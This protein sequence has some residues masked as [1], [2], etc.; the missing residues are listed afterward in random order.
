[1]LQEVVGHSLEGSVVHGQ[2]SGD[3]GV[4]QGYRYES[5]LTMYTLADV[6]SQKCIVYDNACPQCCEYSK[7]LSDGLRGNVIFAKS[8][9]DCAFQFS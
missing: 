4:W 5:H 7:Q 9:Q 3:R 1:M 6:T 8:C 2:A